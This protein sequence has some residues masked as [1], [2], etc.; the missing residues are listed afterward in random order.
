MGWIQ[1]IK[2]DM[3]QLRAAGP[4]EDNPTDR[5]TRVGGHQPPRAVG[6]Q[7]PPCPPCPFPA[8]AVCRFTRLRA[9]G[10]PNVTEL[11]GRT[12]FFNLNTFPSVIA[13]VEHYST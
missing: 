6:Q 12:V 9:R 13:K 7:A 1:A 2:A 5:E 8:P 10:P 3:G 11:Q 4:S